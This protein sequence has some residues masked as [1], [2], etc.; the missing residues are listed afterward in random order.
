MIQ[1]IVF[2]LLSILA[3]LGV[4][5]LDIAIARALSEVDVS[6]PNLPPLARLLT[7][8]SVIPLGIF[9]LMMIGTAEMNHFFKLRGTRPYSG[10]AGVIIGILCLSP[11]FAAA[12]W[13]GH[14][15]TQV[16]GLYWQ[17]VW[18]G[19]GVV[20]TGVL[21]VL[22]RQPE[23]AFRDI[24]ATWIMILYLGFLPSFAVLLRCGPDLPR[25]EDG[26]WML[27]VFL[28][29]VKA[30]DI[31]GYLVGTT[32]GR[33]KL[34]PSISPG[35]SIE[36][37]VGGVAT[38]MLVAVGI[39]WM[40]GPNGTEFLDNWMISAGGSSS[41]SGI[42]AFLIKDACQAFGR[43][44]HPGALDPLVRAAI[45]GA[46]IAAVGLAG[47]L[48]ESSFKRDVGVKDSGHVLPR[49]GGILDL[50]DSPVLALPVAWFLL[51]GVWG[52]I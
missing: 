46:I 45:F 30:S 23:N 50:V 7:R 21:A 52:V 29:V 33:H 42:F 44:V 35:K 3:I 26:A 15:S 31:G 34:I 5:L 10:F 47:D 24:G 28:L 6:H 32:C 19:A 8:G 2:G 17:V 36:G 48:L 49:F 39:A 25:F 27:L 1:R 12:E 9:V 43:S 51:T 37:T 11:W 20:G 38:S 22:R 18:L 16:E 41:H 14:G 13:L 4:V 40:G